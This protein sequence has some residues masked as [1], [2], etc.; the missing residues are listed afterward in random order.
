MELLIT[1]RLIHIVLGALWVGMMAFTVFFLTPAV[2]DAGPDGAKVMAALQRRGVMTVMPII[3]LL[4]IASGVWLIQRVY[5]GMASLMATR[6]GVTLTA[7]AVAS[8]IAFLLGILVM[9]PAMVRAAASSDPAE[10]Q[11]LRARGAAV[12]RVV[13]SLLIF[14]VAAMAVARYV[15]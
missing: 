11:R 9:R 6:T 3:A 4:T 13:A 1:L 2:R 14:A 5:G 10:V 12:G 8:L 15:G 7:G